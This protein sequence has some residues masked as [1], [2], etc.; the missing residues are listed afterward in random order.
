MNVPVMMYLM[1]WVPMVMGAA[2][3]IP[4][5]YACS[6]ADSTAWMYLA[7]A[8]GMG[9]LGGSLFYAGR[10]HKQY[11]SLREAAL[12]TFLLWVWMCFLGIF[13]Y[14]C[15]GTLNLAEAFLESVC[16]ATTTGFTLLLYY[17]DMY[18]PILLW[19]AVFGWVG[20]LAFL[21]M[22]VTVLPIVSGCFGLKL[23]FRKTMSFSFMLKQMGSVA[24]QVTGA[25]A[26][27][28]GIAL[29]LFWLVGLGGCDI[30]KAA[31]LTVS[32][33]GARDLY[34][35]QDSEKI[36][37]AE[38]VIFFL[39][40][41]S[42]GNVLRYWRTVQRKEFSDFYRN[43]EIKVFI[44]FSLALGVIIGLHL[45]C[46]GEFGFA[47][48]LRQA[49]FHTFSFSST[50]GYEISDVSEWPDF[51][52]LLLLLAGFVGG[53]LGS[54]T[55]GLKVIRFIVLFK[56]M[57][58]EAKR[59]LHPHMVSS[60]IVGG[61]AVPPALVGRILSFFFLYVLTF[62]CFAMVLSLSGLSMADAVS[63]AVAGFTTVGNTVGF[64]GDVAF[65]DMPV[66]IQLSIGL[67]MILGRIEIFA[68]LVLAQI[69]SD[70]VRK[71][72]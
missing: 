14:Y 71:K 50:M 28:T 36:F 40:V 26:A 43:A 63:V 55:G 17:N 1:S 12:F 4:F 23:A 70:V 68:F 45:W 13:P 20:G 51:D 32:T 69:S 42:C 49:F 33:T 19:H 11:V 56:L 58:V 60:V 6:I 38:M 21:V 22:V 30:W 53:C 46:H 24:R 16:T 10:T 41:L 29:F 44:F 18:S 48:A 67:F 27:L 66:P 61:S 64:T 72:W 9:A 57:A 25:Y 35:L 31:L 39:M 34:V 5:V 54:P 65:L 15:T 62:F 2:L 47:E 52:R 3:L 37:W 8:G 59:A 7:L